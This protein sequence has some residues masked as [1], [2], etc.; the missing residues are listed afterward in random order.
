MVI[1]QFQWEVLF[2]PLLLLY[3]VRLDT[4][5]LLHQESALSTDP[6]QKILLLKIDGKSTFIV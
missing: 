3:T 1:L 6:I 2:E 4:C 5:C